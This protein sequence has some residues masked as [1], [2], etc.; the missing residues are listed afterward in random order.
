MN[1]NKNKNKNKVYE[2]DDNEDDDVTKMIK[3]GK[4]LGMDFTDC[5]QSI[6]DRLAAEGSFDIFSIINFVNVK[7][8]FAY[9]LI[10]R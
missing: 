2:A 4:L 8:L 5:E 7:C 1:R 9:L 6:R 10:F 3:M